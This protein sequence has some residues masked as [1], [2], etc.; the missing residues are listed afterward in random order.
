MKL[1][2]WA[3]VAEIVG[4]AAVI[5]TLAYVAV[6]IEQNTIGKYSTGSSRF[7]MAADRTSDHAAGIGPI[8]DGG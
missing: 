5:V 7:W 8:G 1:S 4:A 2:D 3:N 6:Q